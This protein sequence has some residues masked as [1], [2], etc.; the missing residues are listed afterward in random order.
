MILLNKFPEYL[1]GPVSVAYG[2][3]DGMHAGH[4]SVLRT[5]STERGS[6]VL[7][8]LTE[9]D[10]F[11]LSTEEEK[12]CFAE[13]AG[14]SRMISIPRTRFKT[15]SAEALIKRILV[16]KLH[17]SCIVTGDCDPNLPI[18]LQLSVRYGFR[19]RTVPAEKFKS[20]VISSETIQKELKEN[21]YPS[22]CSM[23]GHGYFFKNTVIHGKG[24]G[25]KFGMPTANILLPERKILPTYGVYG[26]KVTINGESFLGVTN[27]GLRPSVDNSSVP[28]VETN[29]LNFDRDIYGETMSLELCLFVRETL[30]F[31][32]GLAEVKKQIEKDTQTVRTFFLD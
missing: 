32:N 31:K 25:K 5:L 18:L 30:K 13:K 14:I 21:D 1:P 16:G 22:A 29:I 10:S 4:L 7:L 2:S 27:I 9:P 26:S 3:F 8:S 24:N 6:T 12:S 20:Q 23:L 19:V 17:A 28:T 15:L 11:I